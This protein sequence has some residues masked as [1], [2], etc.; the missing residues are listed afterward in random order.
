MIFVCC[1]SNVF[2]V[3]FIFFIDELC[4]FLNTDMS[5]NDFSRYVNLCSITVFKT[6]SQNF[7]DFGYSCFGLDRCTLTYGTFSRSLA[8]SPGTPCIYLQGLDTK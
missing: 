6:C 2:P 7:V 5:S 1:V 4:C 8:H 3:G